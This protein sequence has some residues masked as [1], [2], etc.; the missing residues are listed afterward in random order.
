MG[1]TEKNKRPPVWYMVKEAAESMPEPTTYK[2][3]KEH[4]W[5]RY[6]DVKERTINCQIIICSVNQNSRVYYPANRKPRECN[7]KYDFLYTLGNGRVMLYRPEEHGRW[8]IVEEDS[9]LVVKRLDEH[10]APKSKKVEPAQASV[11]GRF[12]QVRDVLFNNLGLVSKNLQIYRDQSG[13]EGFEYPTEMGII[14]ILATDGNNRLIVMEFSEEV[15]PEVLSRTLAFMGWCR[16]NLPVMKEV[17]G[18]IF[19]NEVDEQMLMAISEI[20][21]LEVF[22]LKMSLE[23]H[24]RS[25]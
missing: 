11:S 16:K 15:T 23:V 6:P 12:P 25:A 24:K 7:T 17:K 2:Q 1:E 10:K 5:K 20:P 9:K 21:G 19:T 4:I 18:M 13:R 3:I 22:E 8:G 14:D